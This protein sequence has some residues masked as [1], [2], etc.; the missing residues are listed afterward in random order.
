MTLDEKYQVTNQVL[1]ELSI[2]ARSYY[3]R[4][5]VLTLSVVTK[6]IELTID[7]IEKNNQNI[8]PDEELQNH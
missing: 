3:T 4:D 8:D 2:T 6:L 7:R 1:K 5:T